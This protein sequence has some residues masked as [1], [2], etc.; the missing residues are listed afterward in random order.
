MQPI[1]TN[2][3]SIII[4][5]YN[6]AQ[7]LSER[8]ESVL[9]QTYKDFEVIILDDC[10]TDNSRDVIEHYRNHPKVSMIVYNETNSGSTFKQWQKGFNLANGDYIWIAESD[11]VA[12]PEFIESMMKG[13][14]CSD[15]VVLAFSNLDM[16]DKQGKVIEEKPVT[17]YLK[18]P[19][20]E[21]KYYI[22][23]NMI[24][25]CNI[26]N[27]SSAVFSRKAALAVPDD[28]MS[29][30][31]AGDYLF[32][33]EIARQGNVYKNSNILDHFRIHNVKVTPNMVASGTQFKEVNRIFHRL[34]DLG[35]ID[36]ENSLLA[37][38]FWLKRIEDEKHKFKSIEIYGQC[39]EI[40]NQESSFP[41][42]AKYLYLING[43]IR[44]IKKKYLGYGI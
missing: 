10:S 29:F 41:K 18:S 43:G 1:N 31:G 37:V 3:V 20:V 36:W 44:Y 13:I 4:P 32:W 14:K 24:F 27:A 39:K 35:F 21:G 40:W 17:S 22:R 30:R 6:H 42:M 28:F 34:Q 2:M 15:N 25:G 26:L 12:S 8:I 16:I 5:N 38:G 7:F 33:I 11:D 19:T 9:N 23:H